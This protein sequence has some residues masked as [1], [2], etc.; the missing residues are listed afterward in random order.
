MM[1]LFIVGLLFGAIMGALIMRSFRESR[2]EKLEKIIREQHELIE[3]QKRYIEQEDKMKNMTIDER[4]RR[5]ERHCHMTNRM[6]MM[7]GNG[8]LVVKIFDCDGKAVRVTYKDGEPVD[9]QKASDE[10]LRPIKPQDNE[11]TFGGF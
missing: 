3:L 7:T 9:I 1:E 6:D 11:I 2:M 8:L 10:L 4:A 5:L